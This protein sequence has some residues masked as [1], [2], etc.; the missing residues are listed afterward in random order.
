[1]TE[2]PAYQ[3]GAPPSLVRDLVD[4]NRI[5]A[6]HQIVDAFGHVSARHPD[7]PNTYLISRSLAPNLVAPTDI[8]ALDLE[9]EPRVDSGMRS[10]LERFIHG[11]IYRARPD[12]MAVVH[13]HAQPLI[14][15]GATRNALRPIFHM[16]G[17]LG[18][19]CAQYDIRDRSGWTDMLV[20]DGDRARDLA[21]SLGD[22]PIVLMR[23]HGATV[24]GNTVVQAVHRTYY[25]T[26]NAHLQAE[27]LKLGT[28]I[29]LEEEEA[30]LAAEANDTS[31]E[32]AWQL[33]LDELK[34][35]RQQC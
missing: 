8:M 17:F 13:C 19:G 16:C 23:G 22:K 11:E 3:C 9:S 24:V 2:T 26:V 35:V 20:R 31:A 4:A 27:A 34:E 28:P 15:F 32:R 29:Y 12:V 14:P 25:A 33:W 1:M 7:D 18:Q 10:Y 30:R 6:R 21:R 5:L